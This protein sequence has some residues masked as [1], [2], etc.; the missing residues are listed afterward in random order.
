[1]LH[2]AK[3]LFMPSVVTPSAVAPCKPHTFLVLGVGVG[4]QAL[5]GVPYR[6]VGPM[7]SLENQHQIV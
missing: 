4:T 5:P 2:V 1:M 3:Q 7:G 6:R